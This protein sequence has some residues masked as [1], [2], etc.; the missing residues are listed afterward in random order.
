MKKTILFPITFLI[1]SYCFGQTE[2]LDPDFGYDGIQVT[3]IPNGE[4]KA[5]QLLLLPEGK[6]LVIGT[7]KFDVNREISLAQYLSDGTLDETFGMQGRVIAQEANLGTATILLD[8][9][10]LPDGK[11]A[12]ING[13]NIF[14]F[15]PDGTFVEQ[16]STEGNSPG[17]AIFQPDGKFLKARP[18]NS[19]VLIERYHFNGELDAGFTPLS[20]DLLH[21][22]F[23][24]SNSAFSLQPNGK[25]LF[26]IKYDDQFAIA[27]IHAD[28]SLDNSFGTNGIVYLNDVDG[29][30]LT[31]QSDGKILVG[32]QKW[33]EGSFITRLNDDGSPDESFGA[34]GTLISDHASTIVQL[35]QNTDG[36]ILALGYVWNASSTN[37]AIKLT[38]TG[39]IDDNFGSNGS[40]PIESTA[41]FFKKQANQQ[42]VL[43]GTINNDFAV[44]RLTA[45]GNFDPNFN[46]GVPHIMNLGNSIGEI[47]GIAP[48]PTGNL[49]VL[50]R[51]SNGPGIVQ[52]DPQGNLD[53]SFNDYTYNNTYFF[54][55]AAASG[56]L[57]QPDG[58][59][60]A[61]AAWSEWPEQDLT[62]GTMIR[63]HTDGTVDTSF[64]EI[65]T[66]PIRSMALQQ[67]G[68]ILITG[69]GGGLFSVGSF[70]TRHLP[71]GTLDPDFENMQDLPGAENWK[72]VASLNNGKII[73]GGNIGFLESKIVL[74]GF[75][76]DGS[77]DEDFGTN[78]IINLDFGTVDEEIVSLVIQEDQKILIL[79]YVYGKYALLRFH[80]NG[81]PDISFGENGVALFDPYPGTFVDLTS[82]ALTADQKIVVA[83]QL[84][85]WWGG[86]DF[87]LALFN[88]DGS[89]DSSAVNGGVV[90]TDLGGEDEAA[91]AVAVQA[92]GKIVLAGH[93]DGKPALVRYLADL[94]VDVIEVGN[95]EIDQLLIAPN[96]ASHSISIELAESSTRP[97]DLFIYSS[98]GKL[99]E[100]QQYQRN[101]L[102]SVDQL[103]DGIYFVLAKDGEKVYTSRFVKN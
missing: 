45:D 88:P 102:L 59:I 37:L 11:I 34:D 43:A 15:E 35:S 1:L 24:T 71:N 52:F 97:L 49:A 63:L 12:I 39:L 74:H 26:G 38:P 51:F 41:S 70:L 86:D 69:H 76:P 10:I 55:Y 58:K 9:T 21:G 42:I 75:L 8:A 79:G 28:G 13:R 6:T 4:D 27:R 33:G 87:Y 73:V 60:I 82:V 80:P 99:V 61:G 36:S 48:T 7:S 98:D 95:P 103:P 96:P 46:E 22:S 72:V 64:T 54:S 66:G 91:N 94:T 83:G 65:E 29:K 101:Q 32:G 19:E 16:H 14:L 78:G 40:A 90:I 5:Q 85:P 25:V 56:M 67:D 68:K 92:D 77:L 47:K 50:G 62:Y 23:L 81:M 17:Q 57:L 20:L 3:V 31:C 30:C 2:L 44:S 53:G 18:Y 89:Q 84:G 93:A 100:Q